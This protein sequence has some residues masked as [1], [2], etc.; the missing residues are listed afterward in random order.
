MYQAHNRIL[1]LYPTFRGFGYVIF[2]GAAN[3]LD[4]G[5]VSVKNKDNQLIIDKIE[6]YISYYKPNVVVTEN[7]TGEGSRRNKRIQSLVQSIKKLERENLVIK[8]YSRSEIT[9]VF[10]QFGAKTKY[11]MSNT[12]AKFLPVF[13]HHKP[14]KR[15]PWMSEDSRMAIFDAIALAMTYFYLEE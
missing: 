1:S 7:P 14:P 2:E 9:N 12:I 15:K 3:P 4:W 13:E 10:E 5:N 6:T 11:E 8:T